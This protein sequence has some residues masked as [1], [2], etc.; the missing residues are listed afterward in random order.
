M[1]EKLIIIR[2]FLYRLF[3]IGFVL[4]LLAQ[5]VFM[6]AVKGQ[7]IIDL[8]VMLNTPPVYLSTLITSSII[9]IRVLFLYFVLLPALALHWTIARDKNIIE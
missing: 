7:G 1:K 3:L 2:N 9:I 5:F 6:A 8:S 4:S